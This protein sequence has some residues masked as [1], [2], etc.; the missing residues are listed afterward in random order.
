MKDTAWGGGGKSRGGGGWKFRYFLVEALVG[1]VI[2]CVSME[3]AL[4]RPEAATSL[5]RSRSRS[6][7]KSIGFGAQGMRGRKIGGLKR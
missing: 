1:E 5:A 2:T 4:S 7:W 3:S 6:S